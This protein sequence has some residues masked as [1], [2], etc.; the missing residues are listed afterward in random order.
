M[1]HLVLFLWWR[2]PACFLDLYLECGQS[3]CDV[4]VSSKIWLT[5]KMSAPTSFLLRS[6]YEHMTEFSKYL[7]LCDSN[8]SMFRY[9]SLRSYFSKLRATLVAQQ[10][11][12]LVLQAVCSP[13]KYNTHMFPEEFNVRA[14]SLGVCLLNETYDVIHWPGSSVVPRTLLVLFQMVWA[15]RWAGCC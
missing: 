9:H 11:L 1:S 12:I 3:K 10:E 14:E 13:C 4:T 2:N 7:F 8:K 15:C 6:N 5:R